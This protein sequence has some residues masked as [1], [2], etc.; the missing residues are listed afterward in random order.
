MSNILIVDDDFNLRQSFE[1]ILAE[2]GH[3]VLSAGT[4]EAGIEV[5]KNSQILTSI[6]ST[7]SSTLNRN[8]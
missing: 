3:E 5:I 1:K 6:N 7:H 4:G 8:L 2:E